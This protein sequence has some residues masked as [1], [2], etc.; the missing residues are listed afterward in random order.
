MQPKVYLELVRVFLTP[1]AMADS[2]A[3]L[4]LATAIQRDATISMWQAAAVMATSV[5]IYWLGMVLNDLFDR[6]KDL[7]GAPLR[8]IPSGRIS[9]PAVVRL[10]ISLGGAALLVS[11]YLKTAPLTAA[12]ML[13]V[14]LY[15][16]GCKDLPFVG[17]VLMGLCR[18]L[19]FLLG[20]AAVLGMEGLPRE[21]VI[22]GALVLTG[23]VTGVTAVSRIEEAPFAPR[24]FALRA[25]PIL[26]VPVLLVLCEPGEKLG[27]LNG[28]LLTLLLLDAIRAG[29][30]AGK[31]EAGAGPATGG[32]RAHGAALF[33]GKALGGIFLVDAGIV[34]ALSPVAAQK[35][36]AVCTL[37]IL[38]AVL[39]LWRRRAT[40]GVGEQS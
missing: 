19:N 28:S 14:L 2:Y 17:N 22:L 21:E 3:G 35:I 1:S 31:A 30:R 18:G 32:W 6:E 9:V 8:P 13:S 29:W 27:W 7:K 34:I 39:W 25:T 33:V 36:Q 24:S 26:L 16:R 20:S 40:R 15:D 11:I 4:L 5:L 12:L 38:L 10:A 37:Y 23:Y